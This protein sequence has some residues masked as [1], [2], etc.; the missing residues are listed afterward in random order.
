MKQAMVIILLLGHLQAIVAP[1]AENQVLASDSINSYFD[2]YVNASTNL[3]QFFK[4]YEKA[5]E[6]GNEKE[7]K[8]D[9]ETMTSPPVLKTPSPIEKQ[10]SGFYADMYWLCFLG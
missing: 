8:T 1:K 4:L 6:S 9:F 5:L 3:N 2:G 7:V 10:M